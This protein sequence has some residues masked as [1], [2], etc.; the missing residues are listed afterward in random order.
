MS[1][2]LGALCLL[3]PLLMAPAQSIDND[4]SHANESLL[5]LD[6][7]VM[8]AVD[9][10]DEDH[11]TGLV[12]AIVRVF[13]VSRSFVTLRSGSSIMRPITE[14]SAQVVEWVSG[15]REEKTLKFWTYC[16]VYKES[17]VY[18]DEPNEKD[19]WVVSM[20]PEDRDPLWVRSGDEL[21]LMA[22]RTSSKGPY[23]GKYTPHFYR[24]IHRTPDG[25]ATATSISSITLPGEDSEWSRMPNDAELDGLVSAI[26]RDWS[27]IAVSL[28]QTK[29]ALLRELQRAEK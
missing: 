21:I 1:L 28:S 20:Q 16:T 14:C 22:L 23:R 2:H 25:N 24:F 11:V 10:V 5:G 27:P 9:G 19:A 3:L 12:V 8:S 18:G 7:D 17:E 13:E 29:E 15:E 26:I 6:R 4:M